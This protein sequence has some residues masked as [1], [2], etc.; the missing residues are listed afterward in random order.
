MNHLM[1]DMETLSTRP[2]AVVLSVGLVLMNERGEPTWTH[3]TVLDAQQ[4]IAAGRDVDAE[5]LAWWMN[6]SAEARAVFEKSAKYG[7]E[8]SSALTHIADELETYTTRRDL[9]VWSNAASFD[10][11]ILRSLYEQLCPNKWRVWNYQNERCY[12]TVVSILDRE[13]KFAPER[14]GVAHSALD[15]AIWQAEYLSILNKKVGGTILRLT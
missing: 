2:N 13:K 1:I 3:E 10:I 8:V 5:T 12:R 14:S 9:C 7:L 15:D 6:Q 11:V 4:Q